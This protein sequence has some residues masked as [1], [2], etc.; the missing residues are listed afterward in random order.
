MEIKSDYKKLILNFLLIILGVKIM[1]L[2]I[3]SFGPFTTPHIIRQMDTMGVTLRYWLRWTIEEDLNYPFYP[4]VLTA[5]DNYGIT[6]TE[7]P[8]LNIL[9]APFFALP[10][11]I[12]RKVS[13][14]FF[15]TMNLLLA[16]TNFKV[17]KQKKV[18]GIDAGL[19]MALIPIISFSGM[20]IGRFMPD[21]ASFIFVSI[22]IGL[23]WEKSSVYFSL[24]LATLGMLL[25]PVAVIVFGLYLINNNKKF[26]F[27]NI[28]KWIM[29]SIIIVLLYYIYGIRELKLVSDI[30][31][32]FAI[33]IKSP[34]DMLISFFKH[35]KGIGTVLSKGLFVTG[36]I[37][38]FL[39]FKLYRL[40][41]EKRFNFSVLWLVALLQFIV[42]GSLGGRNTIAH[43]YYFIGMSPVL[44]F[45]MAK[46]LFEIKNKIFLIVILVTILIFNLER[47]FYQIRPILGLSNKKDHTIFRECDVLRER[48]TSFPWKKGV[49]FRSD[50]SPISILG[51]CFGEIQNSKVSQYGFYFK[52]D[53][54]PS[55]CQIVD[56]TKNINLVK[57]QQIL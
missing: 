57:C 16:Y 11:S 8:I 13:Y 33:D 35:Y 44:C 31:K 24:I 21:F 17:W 7:F 14:L 18:L 54:V 38:L 9:F 22:A 37:Y 43:P 23:S 32:Y 2:L 47:G 12:A 52:Q 53:K 50:F 10:L 49:R 4:A 34:V 15:I 46:F 42:V 1:I 29:P 55:E 48:N 27:K 25:K 5:G 30:P 51:L 45:I 3:R 39:I 19:A 36:L 41:K 20:Y 56:K 28:Y 40:V 26:L 6:P